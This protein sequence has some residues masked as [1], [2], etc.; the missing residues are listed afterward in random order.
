[1]SYDPSEDEDEDDIAADDDDDDDDED[2]D[3]EA[4]LLIERGNQEV[5]LAWLIIEQDP[6][7]A[8]FQPALHRAASD[9]LIAWLNAATN[10]IEE[11]PAAAG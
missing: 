7:G 6:D 1:M 2:G 10:A 8:R 5:G 9:L 11:R 4:V 3:G